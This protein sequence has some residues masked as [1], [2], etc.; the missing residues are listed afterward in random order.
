MNEVGSYKFG[1]EG[2]QHI[3]QQDDG[4]RNIGTDEIEGSR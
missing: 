4:F 3:G 2:G 1:D